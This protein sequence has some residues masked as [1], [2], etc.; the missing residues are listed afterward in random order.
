VSASRT[1]QKSDISI[2]GA[3]QTD[4]VPGSAAAFRSIFPDLGMIDKFQ[5]EAAGITAPGGAVTCLAA[6]R[7]A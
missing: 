4:A 5:A 3:R 6:C 1:F 7:Q 2:A